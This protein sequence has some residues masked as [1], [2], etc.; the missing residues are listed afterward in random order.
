ML[1]CSLFSVP[2]PFCTAPLPQA[3]FPILYYVMAYLE[4]DHNYKAHWGRQ[5]RLLTSEVTAL[6][7]LSPRFP[8]LS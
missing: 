1:E 8:W 2:L 4:N 3:Q 5:M 6:A 7:P